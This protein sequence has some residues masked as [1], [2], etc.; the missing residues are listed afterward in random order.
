MRQPA[1]VARAAQAAVLVSAPLLSVAAASPAERQLLQPLAKSRTAVVEQ[2]GAALWV[3][4]LS[5]A[6][7]IRQ[8]RSQAARAVPSGV[9]STAIR[10]SP[11]PRTYWPSGSRT[12]SLNGWWPGQ[13][14]RRAWNAPEGW[15]SH[16][17]PRGPRTGLGRQSPE[18]VMTVAMGV[19]LA[20]QY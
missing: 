8:S 15:R 18:L 17:E 4:T 9:T 16:H 1:A 5:F 14:R 6:L 13:R 10:I 3:G 7:F 19:M 2:P 12:C 11:T 20:R